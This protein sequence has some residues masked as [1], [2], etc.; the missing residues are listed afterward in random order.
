MR[1]ANL[2]WI[3]WLNERADTKNK[4]QHFCLEGRWLTHIFR[5]H[6]HGVT[7]V[8]QS[9]SLS[10]IFWALILSFEHW[11]FLLTELSYL[12]SL[13]FHWHLKILNSLIFWNALIFPGFPLC[14]ATLILIYIAKYI[15]EVLKNPR[16]FCLINNP[17]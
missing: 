6:V 4:L 7:K 16:L 10:Y 9:N 2:I 17:S 5:E 11:H 12:P 3:Y 1:Y 8:L 14:V 13:S 15:F